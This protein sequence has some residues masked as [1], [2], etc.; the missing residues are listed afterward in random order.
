MDS[1]IGQIGE[2]LLIFNGSKIRWMIEKVKIDT[3]FFSVPPDSGT[4]DIVL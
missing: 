4:A 1:Q 3:K 2:I